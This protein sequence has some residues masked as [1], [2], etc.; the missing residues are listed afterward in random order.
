MFTFLNLCFQAWPRE[1]PEPY[2]IQLSYFHKTGK[3]TFSST[4]KVEKGMDLFG[5]VFPLHQRENSKSSSKWD[6]AWF[7]SKDKNLMPFTV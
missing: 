4:G 3:E 6:R 1:K 7:V 2:F 5:T